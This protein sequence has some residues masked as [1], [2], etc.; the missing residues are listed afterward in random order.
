MFSLLEKP[1]YIESLYEIGSKLRDGIKALYLTSEQEL[2]ETITFE[3]LMQK[4]EERR[5][6]YSKKEAAGSKLEENDANTL[7]ALL[8]STEKHLPRLLPEGPSRANVRRSLVQ[9]IGALK[10]KISLD[11]I[12]MEGLIVSRRR[13]GDARFSDVF[14]GDEIAS[15]LQIDLAKVQMFCFTLV[16]AL[17]YGVT[18]TA[19]FLGVY[20]PYYNFPEIQ[21][22]IAGFLAIS[23]A[24]Y[25]VYKRAPRHTP[26]TS[27]SD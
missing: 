27:S 15:W 12:V 9:L 23:N 19:M 14:F 22:A 13:T 1:D 16:L 3:P 2:H 8:L 26:S 17:A 5:T 10:T 18:T 11:G 4:L 24:G 21:P 20:P 6:A 7:L 25:L